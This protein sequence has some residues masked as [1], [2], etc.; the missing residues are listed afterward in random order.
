VYGE[1]CFMRPLIHVS[2]N[3]FNLGRESVA[4][5]EKNGHS[6]HCFFALRIQK[7]VD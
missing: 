1:K 6:Q 5:E 7:L 4:K 2:R 3:K